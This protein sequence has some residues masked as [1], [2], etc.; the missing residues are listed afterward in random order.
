MFACYKA[1]QLVGE[2]PPKTSSLMAWPAPTIK[3]WLYN[4]I[5]LM[6]TIQL[7][8]RMQ[9]SCK[10]GAGAPQRVQMVSFYS[11]LSLSCLSALNKQRRQ[12]KLVFLPN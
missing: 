3:T 11:L 8:V 6:V 12:S 7:P 1:L 2:E 4:I 10:K 5:I 9:F